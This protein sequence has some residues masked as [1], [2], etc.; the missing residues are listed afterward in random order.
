MWLSDVSSGSAVLCLSSACVF[1]CVDDHSTSPRSCSLQRADA[2]VVR[3]IWIGPVR[4]E[5]LNRIGLIVQSG[6]HKRC[7]AC[8]VARV[9]VYLVIKRDIQP[10]HVARCGGFAQFGW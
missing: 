10:H 7:A 9:D 5:F 8:I 1:Q 2:H 4:E 6:E 3:D